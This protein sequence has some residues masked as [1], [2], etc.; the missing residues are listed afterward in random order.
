MAP[1][2]ST[3]HSPGLKYTLSSPPSTTGQGHLAHQSTNLTERFWVGL[4]WS[5][6]FMFPL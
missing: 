4:P 3:S 2:L 6:T 5:N 1:V